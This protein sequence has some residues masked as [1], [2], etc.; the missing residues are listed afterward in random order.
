MAGPRPKTYRFA[1]QPGGSGCYL[2]PLIPRRLRGPQNRTSQET[3]R[4]VLSLTNDHLEGGTLR[5]FNGRS[6]NSGVLRKA[7]LSKLLSLKIAPCFQPR[8]KSLLSSL[9]IT[10]GQI[11]HY[12][13]GQLPAPADVE[14]SYITNGKRP[15]P[16][17]DETPSPRFNTV[18]SV[19]RNL[20]ET[21]PNPTSM[22]VA[23]NPS[24]ALGVARIC[25]TR[26]ACALLWLN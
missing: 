4:G 6:P 3:A 24:A 11:L 22:E 16:D 19:F 17:E 12:R 21:L 7:Q 26:P 25:V 1:A 14:V 13:V 5:L 2:P 9:T 23:S 10:T 20:C 15:I 8:A 18:F